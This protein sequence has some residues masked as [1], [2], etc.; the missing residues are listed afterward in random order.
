MSGNLLSFDFLRPLR[1]SAS[2]CGA[3][4]FFRRRLDGGSD[5]PSR[6]WLGLTDGP[7]ADTFAWIREERRAGEDIVLRGM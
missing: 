1:H 3:V 4:W 7:V 5:S 2:G 6:S